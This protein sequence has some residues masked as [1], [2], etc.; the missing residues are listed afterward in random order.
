MKKTF[1]LF[2]LTTL[3]VLAAHAET[4]DVDSLRYTLNSDGTA[5][6]SSCLYT[7]TPEINIPSTVSNGTTDYTVTKIADYAFDGR[8]FITSVTFPETLEEMGYCSFRYCDGLTSLKI[9]A[10]LKKFSSS[11]FSECRNL[12]TVTIADGSQ[13]TKV[14]EAAFYNCNQLTSIKLPSTVICQGT[15]P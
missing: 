7:K 15:V 11:N 14:D 8:S 2:V 6:V 9:P 1:T 13:M 5:T 3:M 12:Q 4:I 10:S